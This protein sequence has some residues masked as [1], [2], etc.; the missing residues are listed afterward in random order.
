MDTPLT[1]VETQKEYKAP[2]FEP[3][4]FKGTAYIFD[5]TQKESW[6]A[7][8]AK[9]IHEWVVRLIKLGEARI[10]KHG[11]YVFQCPELEPFVRDLILSDRARI[12]EELK[13]LKLLDNWTDTGSIWNS[14]LDKAISIIK[15]SR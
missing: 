7:E 15:E 4:E 6:E 10:P 2:Q 12:V 9:L 8:L 11:F 1:E 14:A 13:Q 5:E 3:L